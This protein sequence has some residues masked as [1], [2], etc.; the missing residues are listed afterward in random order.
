MDTSSEKVF[1]Q[2]QNV[3]VTQARFVSYSKY[4]MRNIS[5]VSVLKIDRSIMGEIFLI[6]F[7]AILLATKIWLVGVLVIVFAI[8]LLFTRKDS[9]AVRINSNSGEADGFVSKDLE[10]IKKIVNAL[11][12]A[13]AFRG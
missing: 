12:E 13:I 5:S 9:F 8:V 10:M 7:G 4:A 11:N 1:Y 3:T 6:L 2:D